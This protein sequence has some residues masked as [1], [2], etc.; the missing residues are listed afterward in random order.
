MKILAPVSSVSEAESLIERGAAEFYCGLLPRV[1]KR[2]YGNQLWLSRRGEKGSNFKS[3]PALKKLVEIAHQGSVP[4]FLTLNQQFYL[5]QQYQEVVDLA[6]KAKEYCGIDA[7]IVGDPGLIM[8]LKENFPNLTI[9]VSSLAAVL[10]S[11]SAA[12]FQSL[13]VERIIFPRYLSLEGLQMIMNKVGHT[14]EYE[15]FILNDGCIFEEGY[16]F[17][18]HIFGGAFCHNPTWQ[19]QLLETETRKS[20]FN[21]ASFS[22]HLKDYRQW[23][24]SAIRNCQGSL[25]LGGFPLGMCGLCALP[26]LKKLGV[27][28]LKI[29]GRESSTA[30]KLSSVT[31]VKKVLDGLEAGLDEEA[32]HSIAQE[33]RNTSDNLCASKYMCYYR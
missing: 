4:V 23:I 8:A 25:S 18:N 21:E 29:V 13:G 11:A 19:Y 12:F 10:N 22:Q 17:A 27:K 6:G 24:Q 28:S 1:W 5:P 20:Y 26:E 9:H 7:V 14:V 30:K 31:L 32:I 16:C 15:V 33:L 3:F 2:K